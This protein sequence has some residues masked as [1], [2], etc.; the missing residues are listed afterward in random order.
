MW[1]RRARTRFRIWWK[2]SEDRI[3]SRTAEEILEFEKLRELLRGRSTCAPGKRALDALQCSRD[4]AQLEK[5]FALIREAREWLRAGK[6]LGFGALADPEIAET[7]FAREKRGSGRR[8][9]NAAERAFRDSGAGRA[10]ARRAGNRA[11]GEPDGA[12]GVR[13]AV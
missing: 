9:C 7:D 11:W 4:R 3:M 1:L 8:L 10:A 6:E 5:G 13:R 12:D 2:D